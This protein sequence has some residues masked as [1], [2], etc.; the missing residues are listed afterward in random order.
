MSRILSLLLLVTFVPEMIA[1]GRADFE[2][3]RRRA[4]SE[5]EAKVEA[6]AGVGEAVYSEFDLEEVATARLK[7]DALVDRHGTVLPKGTVLTTRSVLGAERLC[8]FDGVTTLF[9]LQDRD[10]DGYFDRVL[11]IGGGKSRPNIRVPYESGWGPGE[12]GYLRELSYTGAASR[13]LRLSYREFVDDFSQPR[14]SQEAT[15]DLS[16]S[17]PTRI[18]F[19][20][21]EV[22]VLS[23]DNAGIRYR[24]LSGFSPQ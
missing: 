4:G 5:P 22:E 3:R 9:C 15:Y 16:A 11:I 19:K 10:D 18:V 1:V 7:A 2:T 12:R 13:V 6:V 20:G 21:A 14:L 24:V 8:H 23:A 17:G